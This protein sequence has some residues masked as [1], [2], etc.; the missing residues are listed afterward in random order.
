ME[1]II[2]PNLN[3]DF[4]DMHN[5]ESISEELSNFDFSADF[6]SG[7]LPDEE[8]LMRKDITKESK[9]KNL[10]NFKKERRVKTRIKRKENKKRQ[11][12]EKKKLI[13]AMSKEER[14]E[15]YRKKEE[16]ENAKLENLKRGLKSNY[17]IIFD[18]DYLNLMKKT[19]IK[20][21]TSQV[22]YSYSLNKTLKTPFC[23]YLCNYVGE[24]KKEM[25]MM[26]SSNWSVKFY[27]EK[28]YQVEEI[29]KSERDIIY[30]SPDSPNVL[31]EVNDK[32]IYIIGGFVDK[33]VSKFRS[34]D[35]ANGL[36]IK[37][38]RL[39]LD[40]YLKDLVNPVLNINNVVEILASY[41]ETQN[42]ESTIQNLVPGRMIK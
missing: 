41:I 2:D 25:E 27:E 22:S 40:D 32:S 39:P 9:L 24:V 5:S 34:L 23:F 20:S 11:V 7:K 26:G 38:A 13:D 4:T 37:T 21:L 10:E 3:S 6:F 33:P 16:E 17:K 42:W 15:Y 12:E 35:K 18:L 31:S 1:I 8:K 36:D 28:F 14:I 29:I 19:E 30:L